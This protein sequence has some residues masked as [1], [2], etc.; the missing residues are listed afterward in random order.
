MVAADEDAHATDADQ[1]A[2]DLEKVV[3]DVQEAGR[4]Q[5]HEHN[6]PEVDQLRGEDGGV[7]IREDGKI[8]PLHIEEGQ[9]EV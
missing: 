2:N 3:P 6:G 7:P 1:D 9:D 4:E 8:I 5:N